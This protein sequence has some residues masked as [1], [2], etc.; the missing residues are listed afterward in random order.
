MVSN[1][2]LESVMSME[3]EG[4]LASEMSLR[5]YFAAKVMA[6]FT[7]EMTDELAAKMAYK[8]AD[9]MLLARES[10]KQTEENNVVG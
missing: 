7:H 2:E 8:Q 10:K 1:D 6:V 9:E 5:D 4:G 3:D